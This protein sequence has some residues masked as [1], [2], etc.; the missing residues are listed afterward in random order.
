MMLICRRMSTSRRFQQLVQLIYLALS[1]TRSDHVATRCL[2]FCLISSSPARIFAGEAVFI[3]VSSVVFPAVRDAV[4]VGVV[5]GVHD[6]LIADAQA[7]E[8]NSDFA[9]F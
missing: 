7:G 6:A 5:S 3:T 2:L 9:G 4:F 1:L 8:V